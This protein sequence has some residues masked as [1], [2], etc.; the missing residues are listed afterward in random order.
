MKRATVLRLLVLG[1]VVA[2][3]L[4][5]PSL[6]P[7]REA[8]LRFNQWLQGLGNWGLVLL[9]ASYTPA[10]L[11]LFPAWLLTLGA[12]A[13]FDPVSA[14]LAISI[15]STVA[16]AV[17]FL[18]G[19]TIARPR[20]E[21]LFADKPWFG[22]LD[23]AVAAQGFKIVLLTRLSPVFPFT[24]LNYAFSL[25]R[26]SFRTYV[27]ASWIGMLPG[28]VLYVYLGSAAKG[29][30]VLWSDLLAGE[31]T[32]ENLVQAAYF[33]LG[34]VVTVAVAVLIARTAKQ[35]LNRAVPALT[36]KN[37]PA[38]SII[39]SASLPGSRGQDPPRHL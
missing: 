11:L 39:P 18:V 2:G 32:R 28:T 15:G 38:S 30:A 6:P 14:T 12:G 24:W 17:V 33:L 35:A 26:V 31:L 5:L 34:L 21:K 8:A 4:V 25:T 16:A 36:A 29:L 3:L 22:P 19:R 7:V 10:A 23:Q 1:A 20:I 9:A 37:E 27:L 13:A